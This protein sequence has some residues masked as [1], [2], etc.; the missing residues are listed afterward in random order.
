MV[1]NKKKAVVK[2]VTDEATKKLLSTVGVCKGGPKDLADKHDFY[3]YGTGAFP[4]YC[5]RQ[6]KHL[7]SPLL[8]AIIDTLI[9]QEAKEGYT[10]R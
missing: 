2:A 5:R 3:L 8:L 1:K 10:K 6:K 7:T 9:I 4:F